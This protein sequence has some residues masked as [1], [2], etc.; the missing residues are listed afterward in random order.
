M[1]VNWLRLHVSNVCN[2]SC[3]NC[4]VYAYNHPDIEDK[5]MP[6]ALFEQS[7]GAFTRV[8]QRMGENRARVSIYGGEPFVN[9]HICQGI[10]NVGNIQNGVTL[11][12]VINT[13]GSLLND[14]HIEVLRRFDVEIHLSLDG[15]EEV[16]NLSRRTLGGKETFQ[17]VIKTLEK[18]RKADIRVQLNSHVM[19]SNIEHLD[20]LI[21]LAT[22][23]GVQKIYLDL[24]FSPLGMNVEATLKKYREAYFE[25]LKRGIFLSGSWGEVLR[26]STKGLDRQNSIKKHIG[27]E[28]NTDGSYFFPTRIESKKVFRHIKDLESSIESELSSVRY[29]LLKDYSQTCSECSLFKTCYGVAKEH[30]RYHLN[31][32]ADPSSYCDFFRKWLSEIDQPVRYLKSGP[33]L[34]TTT[35]TLP[36]SN[37]QL[38]NQLKETFLGFQTQF[39]NLIA[40]NSA[41]IQI[42]IAQDFTELSAL[43][44]NLKIPPWTKLF[45]RAGRLI[46]MGTAH[47]LEGLKHEMMHVVLQRATVALPAWLEEGICQMVAGSKPPQIAL[48]SQLA[49]ELLSAPAQIPLIHLDQA[50]PASN[51]LYQQAYLMTLLLLHT[52]YEGRLAKFYEFIDQLA[53]G[54]LPENRLRKTI[55]MSLTTSQNAITL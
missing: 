14:S 42:H 51:N 10:E 45:A 4:H 48:S 9:K 38:F 36:D 37:S 30:V 54:E 12:W 43:A 29:E 26:N 18:L 5:L 46:L 3:P 53:H 17:R 35:G 32:Q 41:P 13:N 23:Y 20:Q 33:F 50:P 44:G 19:P 1:E 47:P 34:V 21:E 40:K 22:E 55:Q 7:V 25:G 31:S 49:S 8:L 2:F 28:V 15:K 24:S 39:P 6:L 11:D 16:H 27:I 52:Q